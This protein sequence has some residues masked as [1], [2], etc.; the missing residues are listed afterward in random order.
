MRVIV[1]D[2]DAIVVRSLSTIL[3]AEPDIEVAGTGTS[4]E[5]AVSLFSACEPDVV[6]MDI[7]MPG[8]DG[9]SA[10]EKILAADPAARVVFLTTFSDDDY[11]VRALRLGARGYLIKQDVATIAPALRSVM[12]G[13]SVLEG[14]VLAR[15]AALS[16]DGV[17][18][19]RGE[20]EMRGLTERE[21]EVVRAIADGMSNAE[22][23][24]AL[25]MSEGTVRN[26]ISAILAKLGL[27]NRTQIAVYY[28]RG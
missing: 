13:Q 2:D 3:G 15:A 8:G 22:V 23:A 5:E 16:A 21:R 1:V 24:A 14:E 10:A 9:L 19:S 7:Q 17:R 11:I 6:L 20:P 28:Y 4:G 18:P 27:R 25:Y 26:H 12:A